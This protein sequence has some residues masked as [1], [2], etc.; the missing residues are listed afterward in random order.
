[1]EKK[2]KNEEILSRRG[3][4]KNAAKKALPILG[5]VALV[6]MPAITKAIG[7]KPSGCDAGSCEGG[8][9][10]NSCGGGCTDGC[11]NTCHNTCSGHC[12]GTCEGTCYGSC[13]K[14]CEKTCQGGCRFS[15]D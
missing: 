4:F 11:L 6:N 1:M 9:G 3:F 7:M 10:L 13:D 12:G 14:S 2:E 5:A 8:C 15:S